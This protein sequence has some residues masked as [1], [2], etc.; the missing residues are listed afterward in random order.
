MTPLKAKLLLN[1]KSLIELRVVLYS[2]GSEGNVEVAIGLLTSV[3]AAGPLRTTI[4]PMAD[5]SGRRLGKR[6]QIM[7]PCCWLEN[8]HLLYPSHLA[9]SNLG[10]E[11]RCF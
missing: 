2:P 1:V 9:V 4:Y 7:A 8:Q 11:N 6:V 10:R 5:L 3:G